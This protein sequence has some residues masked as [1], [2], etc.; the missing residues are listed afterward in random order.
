VA[1]QVLDPSDPG[2]LAMLRQH[3]VG[4][5]LALYNVTEHHRAWPGWRV[6]DL[7][8]S[9]VRN[10]LSGAVFE[11]SPDADILLPPYAALWLVSA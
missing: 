2:I 6:S 1:A 8:F 11:I 5:L 7:G 3:P 10:A 4:D 9:R